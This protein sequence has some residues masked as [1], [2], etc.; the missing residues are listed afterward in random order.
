MSLWKHYINGKLYV[1]TSSRVMIQIDGVWV[2]AY[3]YYSAD[4]SGDLTFVRSQKEFH[5]KFTEVPNG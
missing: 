3:S 1:I 2:P 5:E 4:G